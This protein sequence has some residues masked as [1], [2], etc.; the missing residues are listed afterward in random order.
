VPRAGGMP[1][2]PLEVLPHV[3]EDAVAALERRGSVAF[4][5]PNWVFRAT[6][7][8]PDDPRLP[9]LW[10]L[11]R[12]GAPQAW[13]LATGGRSAVVAV[14]D[15][16][17]A[18]DHPDLQANMWAN[19]GEIA[20]NGIDDDANG[21]VDDVRGWD[22]ADGDNDPR[23]LNGHGTHVAGTIA[24]VGNNGVGVTG[25][26]WTA[27]IMPVRVL[28]A[29][30]SGTYADVVEGLDYAGRNGARIVN[31]SLGGSADSGSVRLMKEVIDRYPG[32]LFVA[33]AGNEGSD[34]DLVPQYP[35]N[36]S[37][38]N[39]VCVA[40]TTQSDGLASF[41]NY[42]RE[43]VDLG[44]PGTGILSTYPAFDTLANSAATDGFETGL[45]N[46]K[47]QE[48]TGGSF[49]A[50]AAPSVTRPFPA[51]ADG[52]SR[53]L[54]DTPTVAGYASNESYWIRTESTLDLTGR[55]GCRLAYSIR[56]DFDSAD[57]LLVETAPS[58]DGTWTSR[59]TFT[60]YRSSW[61]AAE[62]YLGS[63][64]AQVYVRFRVAADGTLGSDAPY[65]GVQIDDV[66]VRCIG[67]AYSSASYATLQGTSMAAPLVAGAATVLAASRP[68]ASVAALRS[69]LLDTGDRLAA[70]GGGRTVTG[71]RLNLYEA[72]L[73][74][75]AT[76]EPATAPATAVEPTAATLAGTVDPNG[77]ETAYAI[78]WGPTT[79]YGSSVPL[80]PATVGSGE[81]P[82]AVSQRVT[83]LSPGTAYQYRVV[84]YR[85][86]RPVAY[87]ANAT[88]TTAED[89]IAATATA[90][91]G[92][93]GGTSP[94]PVQ[95]Q[96]EPGGSGDAAPGPAAA[97]GLAAVTP[98]VGAARLQLSCPA[99]CTGRATLK[100]PE[101]LAR[102]LGL[103][104]WAL[105]SRNVALGSGSRPV[106]VRIRRRML[107]TLRR[108]GYAAVRLTL[109]V[110]LTD[111]EG[112][113]T[114]V[115]RSLRVP[116]ARTR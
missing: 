102:R 57:E 26:A 104:R 108:K 10:G 39:V 71:R 1:L 81:E 96:P 68:G 38:P 42:G 35:C 64:G 54:D 82:V 94:P 70:L 58:A 73:A 107:Q 12:I 37:S 28:G 8:T 40:A 11:S 6:A 52:S 60:G 62:T 112:R 87:G 53:V 72:L 18:Y 113:T 105:G 65:D 14:V 103:T 45:T 77:A 91:A 97:P 92:E 32:T 48:G 84:A 90:P 25:V 86:G 56:W 59:E 43:S 98:R 88:V 106:Q 66:R 115:R 31:A 85:A 89:A 34:N 110:T 19:P 51:P 95:P 55:A 29:D 67:T 16:G 76:P 116:V 33:A 7:A 101:R 46:W 4:A 22:A 3:D 27:R 75:Q 15:T 36:I 13:A 100:A 50:T 93:A 69:W 30:G 44:A 99:A 63:D 109:V 47:V 20:G 21:K 24:A 23:D 9:D 80:S 2:A 79:A 83:G 49:Q 78:E 17:V 61:Y 111:A 114:S 74:S 41:S 5:E